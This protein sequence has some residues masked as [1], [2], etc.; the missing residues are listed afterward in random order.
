MELRDPEWKRLEY[1][2]NAEAKIQSSTGTFR[3]IPAQENDFLE[4]KCDKVRKLMSPEMVS[5]LLQNPIQLSKFVSQCRQSNSS[6]TQE[7]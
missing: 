2:L 4:I 6:R 5:D 7:A 1:L 3:V